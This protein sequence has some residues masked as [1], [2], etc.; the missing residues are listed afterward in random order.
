MTARSH[1]NGGPEHDFE[2]VNGLPAHLPEGEHIVWQGRPDARLVGRKVL[3][4]RWIAGYFVVLAVWALIVGVHE[5]RAFGNT[6]ISIAM[7]TILAAVVI[8]LLELFAWGVHKTTL[9]TMTNKRLVFRIGVALSATFNLPYDQIAAV[10]MRER[11]NDFGDIA[12]TLKKGNQMSWLVFWPHV[13]GV[14]MK[15][16]VPQMIGLPNV[17]GAA[18]MLSLQMH[19][20]LARKHSGSTT[21]VVNQSVSAVSPRPIIVAAE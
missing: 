19:S 8:G 9:Y 14:Q 18:E 7:L 12:L 2:P 20:H 16:T 15:M 4:T 3:K 21:S 1:T 13:R 11:G 10:D 17:G 5:G 6:L